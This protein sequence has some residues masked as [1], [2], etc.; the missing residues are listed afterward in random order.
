MEMPAPNATILAKKALLVDRL[1]AA[2][3]SDAVIHAERELKVS[4]PTRSPP[5]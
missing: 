2:L 3:P 5:F 1:N 4:P